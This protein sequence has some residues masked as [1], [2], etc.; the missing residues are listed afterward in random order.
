MSHLKRRRGAAAFLLAALVGVGAVACTSSNPDNAA[1]ATPQGITVS[2][3]GSVPAP[4]DIANLELGVSARDAT[5]AAA[6]QQAASA[7][8][9]VQAA[10]QSNGVENSDIQTTFFDVS[11]QYTS[12]P[13]GTQSITGFQVANIARVTVRQTDQVSTILD[14]AI[15][16]GGDNVRVNGLT[17]SVEDP[18]PLLADARR[19]AIENAHVHADTL[20]GAAGVQLGAPISIVESSSSV[21]RPTALAPEA[22]VGSASTPVSPGE[23]QLTVSVTVV[24]AID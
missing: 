17:F 23:Q 10:L 12:A 22:A 18:D 7:M 2:A 16:A 15:A 20:A 9:N 3:E 19:R 24:Y 21:P 6:R 5:V 1:T 4:P 11:P 14:A 8:Q 13:D